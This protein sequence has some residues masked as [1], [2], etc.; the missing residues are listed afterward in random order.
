MAWSSGVVVVV[1]HTYVRG[2][3]GAVGNWRTQC[4]GAFLSARSGHNWELFA[5]I[6]DEA[7]FFPIGLR[8]FAGLKSLVDWSRWIRCGGW[9]VGLVG[10]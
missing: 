4:Y 1:V 10:G 6:D 9:A 8:K 2:W 5:S 7:L 3:R